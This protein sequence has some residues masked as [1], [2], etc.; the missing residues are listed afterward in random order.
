MILLIAWIAIDFKKQ[1]VPFISIKDLIEFDDKF[2]Q[3]RFRLG[4]HVKNGSISF[5][6]NLLTVFFTLKQGEK[7][8]PIEYTEVAL[9][10][11]FKDDAEVIVE[12]SYID[13]KLIADNLMTKCASRYEE[14]SNYVTP[15]RNK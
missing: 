13:G 3:K 12:G 15:E 6:E 5:S 4:G 11:L 10:D 14:E 9:P 8:L 2:Y 1:E 7:T